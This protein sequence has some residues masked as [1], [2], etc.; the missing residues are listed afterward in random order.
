[1]IDTVYI[2]GYK[3]LQKNYYFLAVDN[4]AE[5]DFELLQLL[6]DLQY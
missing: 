1:M 3:W 4:I 6:G 5:V 2:A